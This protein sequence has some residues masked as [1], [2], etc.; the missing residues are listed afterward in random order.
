MG[1]MSVVVK[2]EIEMPQR[3]TTVTVIP[4]ASALIIKALKEPPKDKNS[5]EPVVHDGNL[6]LEDIVDIAKV[7]RTRSL[8]KEFSG[9]VM[10]ILGTAFSIGCT[11]DGESP[12]AVQE[13]VKSGKIDLSAFGD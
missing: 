7:M 10:E 11:V 8:A 4:S 1:G 6:T 9:T 13:K 12:K 5:D 2:I 3:K